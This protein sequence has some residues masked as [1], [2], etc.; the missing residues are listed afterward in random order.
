MRQRFTVSSP[1]GAVASLFARFDTHAEDLLVLK[2]KENCISLG[3]GAEGANTVCAKGPR[4]AL[5]RDRCHHRDGPRSGSGAMNKARVTE[6]HIVVG[7]QE[8]RLDRTRPAHLP[9]PKPT[10]TIPCRTRTSRGLSDKFRIIDGDR[11]WT[12]SRP[13]SNGPRAAPTGACRGNRL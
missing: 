9:A 6:R 4:R 7:L 2:G 13:L 12:N 10:S 5:P 1:P 3:G 8:R 11:R